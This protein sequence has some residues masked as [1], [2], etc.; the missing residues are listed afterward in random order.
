MQMVYTAYGMVPEQNS[1]L[2]AALY[3]FFPL[4][5]IT[6]EASN[7]CYIVWNGKQVIYIN[8]WKL[9][10]YGKNTSE[11]IEYSGECK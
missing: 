2:Q 1:K 8:F 11:D 4:E 3:R 7:K 6:R 10:T 9:N 5:T